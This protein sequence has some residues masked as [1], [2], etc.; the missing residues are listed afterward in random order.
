LDL[1]H[2]EKIIAAELD[3]AYLRFNEGVNEAFDKSILRT[4]SKR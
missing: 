3:F 4:N 1:L 2:G